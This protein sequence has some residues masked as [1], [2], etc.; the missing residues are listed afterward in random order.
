M[1]FWNWKFK[2]SFLCPALSKVG[3]LSLVCAGV[4][5]KLWTGKWI[6]GSLRLQKIFKII[7]SNH[8]PHPTCLLYHV[9][10]THLNTSVDGDST[11][12]LSRLYYPDYYNSFQKEIFPNIQ[13]E[14]PL[15]QFESITSCPIDV[16]WEKR[17]TSTSSQP[18]SRP[19]LS[20]IFSKLNNPS[21][22]SQCP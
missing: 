13:P 16:T 21:S 18:P 4:L 15:A 10:V 6:I 19:P 9:S 11:T 12:S 8:N 5:L 20:L 14:R 7:K 2:F 17:Q 1:W 3:D 22:L